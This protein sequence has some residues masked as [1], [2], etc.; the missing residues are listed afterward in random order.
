M[1]IKNGVVKGVIMKTNSKRKMREMEDH[2]LIKRY[3]Y[4]KSKLP[5]K[6]IDISNQMKYL[7]FHIRKRKLDI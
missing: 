5:A 2:Q 4:L 1:L 3:N 6:A 7:L